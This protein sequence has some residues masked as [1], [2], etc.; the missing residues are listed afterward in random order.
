MSLYPTTDDVRIEKLRPLVSPAILMEDHP[1]STAGAEQV[2]R[3]RDDS[4]K[5]KLKSTTQPNEERLS[6]D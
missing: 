6:H 4:M 1:L 5:R 2:A 3:T